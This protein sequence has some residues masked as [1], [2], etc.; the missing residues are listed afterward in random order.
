MRETCLFCV[1]KHIAQSVVLVNEA[2]T[3]YPL[4][5]WFAIGHL[6]EAETECVSKYYE[7]A[8]SIR[9][10]RLALM[11]QDGTFKHTELVDL[12]KEARN[13][14]SA[15]NGIAEEQRIHNILYNN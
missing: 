5:I 3:G 14:A 8:Q 10:V 6:A 13:L 12:L 9:K 2:T 4:H 1:S 7:F 11:G 15:V